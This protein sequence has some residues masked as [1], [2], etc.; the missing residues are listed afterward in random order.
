[1]TKGCLTC[2]LLAAANVGAETPQA[3]EQARAL[4]ALRDYAVNYTDRLPDFV[5]TQITQRSFLRNI[6]SLAPP[7]QDTIEEQVTYAGHK[8]SYVV[9]RLNGKAVNGVAHDQVGGLISSG[10]FGSL[11]KNTFDPNAGAEFRWQRS[12]TRDGRKVYI[13]A[14]HVPEANGYSLVESRRTMRVPYKGLVYADA[15]TGAVL[16]IEMECEIPVDSEYKELDLTLDYKTAAVAG[17][18]F[19]LP[20]HFYLHTRRA[21][22]SSAISETVNV[23]DY[24]AYRRFDADS[25]VTFDDGAKP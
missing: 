2:V 7:Q 8:E 25:S 16:R 24:K 14:F 12:A 10:E 22:S 9:T 13:F 3:A 11:L 5:C 1:M 23:A 21:V 15:Q 18:E 4:T 6:R 17:R 19:I 20:F